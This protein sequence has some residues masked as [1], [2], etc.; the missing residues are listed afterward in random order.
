[1]DDSLPSRSAQAWERYQ[2]ESRAFRDLAGGQE[3]DPLW[4][5]AKFERYILEEQAFSRI[6]RAEL[7]IA[8]EQAQAARRECRS[9]SHHRCDAWSDG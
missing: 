8:G 6:C 2:R 1:M 7:R 5:R 4:R 9:A 3:R